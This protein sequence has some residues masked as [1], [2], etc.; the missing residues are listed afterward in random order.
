MRFRSKCLL[1][2]VVKGI[3]WADEKWVRL[4]TQNV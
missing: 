4:K 3:R 1:L 2:R